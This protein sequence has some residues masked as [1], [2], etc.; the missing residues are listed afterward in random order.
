[1]SARPM[2]CPPT[3]ER[4]PR[5]RRKASHINQLTLILGHHL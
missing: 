5:G 2:F 4:K 3:A 1:M